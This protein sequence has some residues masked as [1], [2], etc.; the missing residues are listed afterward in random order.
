MIL[1]D[2]HTHIHESDFPIAPDVV[3]KNAAANGVKRIICVGTNLK[4]SREAVDFAARYDGKFGVRLWAAVGVH[5][6]EIRDF[7]QPDAL[8]ILEKLARQP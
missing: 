1:T 5:P 2:S 7:D 6:S 3:L 8:K 4:T